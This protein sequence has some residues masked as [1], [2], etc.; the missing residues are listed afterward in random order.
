MAPV[1]PV[2]KHEAVMADHETRIQSL[3]KGAAVREEQYR[4]LFISIGKI[5]QMIRD[6]RDDIKAAVNPIEFQS[7]IA[8]VGKLEDKPRKKWE[9]LET[10]VITALA[11]GVIGFLVGKVLGA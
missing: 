6:I 9:S 5:E 7:L 10:I 2:E 3:E 4:N 8:R 11:T 1:H